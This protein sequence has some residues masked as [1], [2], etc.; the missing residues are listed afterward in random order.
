MLLTW[1]SPINFMYILTNFSASPTDFTLIVPSLRPSSNCF[2]PS[3]IVLRYSILRVA[4]CLTAF[5]LICSATSLLRFSTLSVQPN[6]LDQLEIVVMDFPVSVATAARER[7]SPIAKYISKACLC[8]WVSCPI[9]LR[10]MRAHL[11]S[12]HVCVR[13]SKPISNI[14]FVS[15][16]KYTLSSR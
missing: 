4:A 16:L 8:S 5:L 14:S 6:D 15:I 1:L 3:C 12:V 9:T 11:L 10:A 7:E 2:I 13:I